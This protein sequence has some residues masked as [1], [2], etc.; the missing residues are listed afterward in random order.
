MTQSV[1]VSEA[2]EI[3]KGESPVYLSHENNRTGP[4]RPD[5]SSVHLN[6]LFFVTLIFVF[7]EHSFSGRDSSPI[8]RFCL[9]RITPWTISG[10][11]RLLQR[12]LDRH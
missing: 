4:S 3:L 5:S 11:A 2:Q 1:N 12:S 6:L 7:V 10:W 8:T 9:L